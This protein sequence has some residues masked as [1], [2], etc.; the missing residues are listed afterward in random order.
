MCRS[1]WDGAAQQFSYAQMRAV[2]SSDAAIVP[3]FPHGKATGIDVS[4]SG[5]FACWCE[6]GHLRP[7]LKITACRF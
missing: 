6:P 2:L 1:L 3:L 5:M 7:V 4:Y